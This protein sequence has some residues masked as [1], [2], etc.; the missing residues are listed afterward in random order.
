MVR[1]FRAAFCALLMF[2]FAALTCF[3]LAMTSPPREGSPS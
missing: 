3:L 1:F 2:R